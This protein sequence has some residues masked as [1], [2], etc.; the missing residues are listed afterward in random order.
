MKLNK[1]SKFRRTLTQICEKICQK[2]VTYLFL[3]TDDQRVSQLVS[4][5][6]SLHNGRPHDE[7][8]V[9]GPVL[10]LRRAHLAGS[11]ALAF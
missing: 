7:V 6:V 1:L 5:L 4:Q 10:H 3:Q 2:E 8:Y 11:P 9:P